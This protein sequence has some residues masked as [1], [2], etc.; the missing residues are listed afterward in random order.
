V[1]V[2]VTHDENLVV[3]SSCSRQCR[4]EHV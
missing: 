4:C 1:G 3:P 2:Q